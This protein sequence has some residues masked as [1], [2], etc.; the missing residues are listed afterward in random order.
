VRAAT[1]ALTF[2]T[3]VPVGRRLELDAADV[4]RGAVF[5][6]FVGAGIGALAGLAAT[7]LEGPLPP[8]VAGGLAVG[9]A[10]ALTGALH[11]DALAD[12]ADALGG[13][14]RERALEIMRDP[15]IGSFGAVAVVVAVLVEAGALGSLAVHGDALAGFVVA[16]ALSRSAA[17]ALA[18][19]LPYA[20]PEG[21]TGSVLSGT[22]VIAPLAGGSA[23]L[24]LAALLLGWDGVAIAGAVG[25]TA[26]ACGVGCRRWL[27]GVTGDTLGATTQLTE[28]VALVVLLALR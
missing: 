8:L 15:R 6:P 7:G 27:G 25:V 22:A 3:R 20:R 26:A 10:V 16:G 19:L 21:G 5:F 11:I 1:A 12:T 23:A 28:I 14:G 24:G 17:P 4:G 9:L 13:D 18:R 2:L